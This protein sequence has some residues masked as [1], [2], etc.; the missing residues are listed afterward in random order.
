MNTMGKAF[1][2]LIN[3]RLQAEL[4][5]KQIISNKQYGF[6][7]GR[8]TIEAIMSI[9]KK[10]EAENEK[11]LKTRKLVL[12][13][14][15]D[16]KNAFNS[17]SWRAV[18]TS[19]QKYNISI[20]LQKIV[21]SYLSDRIVKC[22][23]I[24]KKMTAG[25]PQGSVLGPTL[26]NIAYN[27]IFELDLPEEA[28]VTG[29][30]DDVALTITAPSEEL[31]EHRAN[32]AIDRI[33][34]WLKQQALEVAALKSEAILITKTYK[35]GDFRIELE[36]EQIEVKN[37][38]KYLGIH[39]DK[40][41]NFTKHVKRVTQKASKISNNLNKIMPRTHGAGETKRKLLATVAESIVCYGA[42]VWDKKLEIKQNAKDLEKTQRITAIRISRAYRTVSNDAVMVIGRCIPWVIKLEVR[43]EIRQT[44][45]QVENFE[46][47]CIEI[48]QEGWKN[49]KNDKGKWTR[50]LITDIK[51]WYFRTHG[52]LT[53]ELTQVL[54]GHGSFQDFL[55]RIGK[56]LS[57]ICEMCDSGQMR[58]I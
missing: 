44:K 24:E 33:S 12:V 49:S 32:E 38:V 4:E 36:G 27:E 52:E 47:K 48:W 40:R 53:Y 5:T 19:S 11:T 54:T 42:P 3:A 31:L 20:Y 57:P 9:I 51:P 26:W 50:R 37:T 10:A 28:E 1:E 21:D 43:R 14:L 2:I 7:K 56:K 58:E 34:Q 8:S 17:I 13:I 15:L 35:I 39:I 46:Q 55:Y 30:A 22:K 41:L 16:I 29:Y 45:E 18:K 23:G 6:R 25:V